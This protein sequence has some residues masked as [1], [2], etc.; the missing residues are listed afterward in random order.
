MGEVSFGV[1]VSLRCLGVSVFQWC[2]LEEPLSEQGQEHPAASPL[3]S[4]ENCHQQLITFFF[5][6]AV[7]S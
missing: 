7:F 2:E 3:H 1:D 6:A 4:G 5:V